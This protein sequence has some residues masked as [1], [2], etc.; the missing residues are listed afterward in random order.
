MILK[1]L[2]NYPERG[3]LIMS[4][5]IWAAI[6]LALVITEMVVPTFFIIFLGIGALIVA[7]TTLLGFS[8]SLN[9]QLLIFAISSILL[10]LL[11]RGRLKKRLSAKEMEPEYLGQLATVTETILPGREG[12]VSYSGS[13]WTAVA[14]FEI[15]KDSTV[16]IIGREGLCL[17]V[18]P[19]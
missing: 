12:K 19:A 5:W 13:V 3:Q 8:D 14:D 15:Q 4:E 2:E 16:T 17:K 7:L 1:Q 18:K 10:M 11:L 9:R 6:G